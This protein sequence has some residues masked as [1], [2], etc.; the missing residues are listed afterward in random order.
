MLSIPSCV[1]CVGLGLAINRRWAYWA[2]LFLPMANVPVDA[3]WIMNPGVRR[4]PGT[5]NDPL[6][7]A[8][9]RGQPCR[10]G[11]RD[12]GA[13]QEHSPRTGWRTAENHVGRELAGM[14]RGFQK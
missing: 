10:G 3:W 11:G 8:P 14:W 12:S 13:D 7:G 5:G 6:R 1:A 4:L 9:G 2:A